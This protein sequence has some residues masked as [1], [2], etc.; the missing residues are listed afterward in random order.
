M[1]INVELEFGVTRTAR[2]VNLL[3]RR[4]VDDE[5]RHPAFSKTTGVLHSQ[6]LDL[7]VQS[8]RIISRSG[9]SQSSTVL[10]PPDP[11]PILFRSITAGRHAFVLNTISHTYTRMREEKSMNGSDPHDCM[12]SNALFVNIQPKLYCINDAPGSFKTRLVFE[13]NCKRHH[14]RDKTHTRSHWEQY[15][16]VTNPTSKSIRFSTLQTVSFFLCSDVSFIL[17]IY[18]TDYI[19]FYVV[20]LDFRIF[21][22]VKTDDNVRDGYDC[23]G[24]F[25]NPCLR[26]L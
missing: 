12:Q 6:H 9:Q 15:W 3:Q 7:Y 16:L 25:C 8:T 26:L 18:N 13:A 22:S 4:N 5:I 1:K 14:L 20:V 10:S 11:P 23:F 19:T 21:P 24:V 17:Y 2:R